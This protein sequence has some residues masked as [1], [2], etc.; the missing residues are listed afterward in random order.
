MAPGARRVT[1]AIAFVGYGLSAAAAS[2]DDWAGI[3]VRDRIVLALDGAPPHLGW[4]ARLPTREAD[5]RADA[6]ARA[7]S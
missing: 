5:C 3:D 1:G 2:Y 6:P 7:R 4:R